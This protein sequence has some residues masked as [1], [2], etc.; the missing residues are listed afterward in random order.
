MST[1]ATPPPGGADKRLFTPGPLTTSPEVRQAMLRDLGSRDEA[2]LAAVAEVRTRLLALYGLSPGRGWESIPLQGSGT[3]AVEAG[4]SSIVPR[5]GRVLVLV[6]GAYGERIVKMAAVHGIPAEVLRW[7]EDTPVDPQ[8]V[9]TA[10]RADPGLSHVALVHVETTSGVLNPLQAVGQVVGA[11]GRVFFVDAM[12]SFG[13]LEIDFEASAIDFLAA[14]SNKCLEGVP[15]LAFVIARRAA[16]ER[17]AGQARS[18]ALDLHA[19]WSGLERDGQ[20][21]FTPP[22]HVLMAL[23]QA[24]L[25]LEREGGVSARGARYRANNELLRSGMEALGFRAYVPREQSSPIIGS[26]LYPAHPRFDFPDFYRRLSA[27]GFLIYP[28][29]LTRAECFRLGN[30]GQLFPADMQALLV[31]VKAVADEMGLELT[32]AGA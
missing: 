21:R 31:A 1:S 26:F 14:S 4:L 32:P 12:S 30:I 11:E 29:K 23:R 18:L 6:N 7:P 16:L 24:L 17:I 20:F 10:L 19:Q 15:G 13:A 5:G 27:R 8:A 22:T 3:Y 2:F 28:G 9:R 25:E